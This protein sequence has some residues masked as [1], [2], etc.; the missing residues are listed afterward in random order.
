MIYP[1]LTGAATLRIEETNHAKFDS[2]DCSGS[3]TVVHGECSGCF[4]V[5][6][7]GR[8]GHR[9]AGGHRHGSH[10]AD[11]WTRCE[12]STHPAGECLG[13]RTVRPDHVDDI[14]GPGSAAG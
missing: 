10:G 5:R 12:R 4:G 11:Y 14:L 2:F 3:P 7:Y 1:W 6:S 13:A 8:A 9:P